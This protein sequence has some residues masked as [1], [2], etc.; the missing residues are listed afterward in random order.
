MWGKLGS[1][2]VGAPVELLDCSDIQSPTHSTP[3]PHG[4]ASL[5]GRGGKTLSGV[6]SQ[7]YTLNL[8]VGLSRAFLPMG[9]DI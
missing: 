2:P 1:F 9:W 5:A 3:L 4:W 6:E 8:K 7:S